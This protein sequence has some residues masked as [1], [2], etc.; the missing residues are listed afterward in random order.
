MRCAGLGPVGNQDETQTDRHNGSGSAT[1]RAAS[2]LSST[3]LAKIGQFVDEAL[4]VGD[5]W[6]GA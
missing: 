1:A 5:Q 4:S 3:P 6:S 2:G